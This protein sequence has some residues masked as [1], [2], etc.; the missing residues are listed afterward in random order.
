MNFGAD[1][2]IEG[3]RQESDSGDQRRHQNGAE[4]GH[5][6]SLDGLFEVES[7]VAESANGGHQEHVIEDGDAREGDEADGGRD[8]K[9][10][11]PDPEGD[12]PTGPGEGDT[13]QHAKRIDE[14][15]IR[16]VEQDQDHDQGHGDN[17]HQPFSGAFVV[18]ELAAPFEVVPTVGQ[19]DLFIDF[20][21]GFGDEAAHVPSADVGRNRNS[22]IAPFASDGRGAFDR[23]YFGQA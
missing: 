16:H 11:V 6:S 15:V 18:F 23:F 19:F 5:G 13:R 8:G 7:V 20:L 14:V 22:P 3:H 10:H 21:L 9:G 17:E 12:D 1:A 2:R 4:P